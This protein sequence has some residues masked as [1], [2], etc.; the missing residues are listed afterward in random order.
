MDPDISGFMPPQQA[1]SNPLKRLMVVTIAIFAG[2]LVWFV[3]DKMYLALHFRV[4]S[5]NPPAS[6]VATI[7]PFFKV[8]FNK[9]LSSKGL[10]VSSKPSVIKSYSVNGDTLDIKLNIPMS[11]KHSYSI[12]ISSVSDTA[13]AHI[14][15]TS[16]SF[17]PKYVQSQNLPSDQGKALLK[18]QSKYTPSHKDPIL[19]YLPHS[20]LDYTL[21][22]SIQ[23]D[24]SIVLQA[25]LLLPPGV[26]GTEANNDIAQYKQEINQYIESIGLNPANYNIQYQIV[27]ES[28]SGV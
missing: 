17:T 20:T 12:I 13:G 18:Q 5:T 27:H 15:N 8:M 21:N 14:L 24:G 2:L 11:S 28:L 10:S 26:T 22:P 1:Q 16:F 3:A 7:S 4:V 23:S 25:Q 9:P 19:S 6:N